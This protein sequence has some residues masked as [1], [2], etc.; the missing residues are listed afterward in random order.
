M[1]LSD[2]TSLSDNEI[3]II[4][5][6]AISSFCMRDF[7]EGSKENIYKTFSAYLYTFNADSGC[8]EDI[9]QT[10]RISDECGCPFPIYAV[11]RP[12]YNP[13]IVYRYL[14]NKWV[15]RSI[16]KSQKPLLPAESSDDS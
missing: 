16:S 13:P 8:Y 11:V 7:I 2:S 9:S 4:N 3:K 10:K 12:K 14:M 15:S 5:D 6:H 1:I